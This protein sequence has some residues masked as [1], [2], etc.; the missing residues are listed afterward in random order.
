MEVIMILKNIEFYMKL[1][2]YKIEQRGYKLYED[3]CVDFIRQVNNK[4]YFK[5]EGNIESN[6]DVNVSFKNNEIKS[7]KCNCV[8]DGNCKH[9]YAVLLYL[10]K[11]DIKE[12]NDCLDKIKNLSKE[13]LL[14]EMLYLYNNYD[15][16]N[17]YFHLKYNSNLNIENLF[18]EFDELYEEYCE[19]HEEV[20]YL[21]YDELMYSYR[22]K[23]VYKYGDSYFYVN[24]DYYKEKFID[25]VDKILITLNSDINNFSRFIEVFVN[26]SNEVTNFYI[27]K[28]RNFFETIKERMNSDLLSEALKMRSSHDH[29]GYRVKCNSKHNRS[30]TPS[31]M[32]AENIMPFF[33]WHRSTL[34]QDSCHHKI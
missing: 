31:S 7:I 10:L 29:M 8:F 15:I 12:D 16:I 32:A 30:T 27:D 5:V 25:I 1:F 34:S 20:D 23:E 19:A 13:E 22:F 26:V 17:D 28:L 33:F 9:E 3:D 18:D 6:Y 21:D 11:F 24:E 14:S 2:N 4:L